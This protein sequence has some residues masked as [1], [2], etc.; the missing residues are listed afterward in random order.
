MNA[1]Q[2]LNL[3]SLRKSC[4]HCALHELCLP[5]GIDADG[6]ERLD[7]LVEKRWLDEG[8]TLFH[9]GMPFDALYVV[10]SGSLRTCVQGAD[11]DLH[12]LGFHLPGE[13][14]GFD[15]ISSGQHAC[16][17]QALE[18]TGYCELPYARLQQLAAQVPALQSQ[19]MRVVSRE[20]IKDQQ[21]LVLLGKQQAQQRVAIFLNSLSERYRRLQRDGDRLT[22]SMSRRDIA[23]YLGLVIETVSRS[24]GRL[25]ELGVLAVQRR[26]I[27]ILQPERLAQLCTA[28]AAPPSRGRAARD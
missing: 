6:M 15:A 10:R 14:V 3:D 1:C 19:L 11:G 8:Q 7:Q 28:E 13:L 26:S 20:I 9:A 25:E 2:P 4:S 12:V 5:A 18:R 16:D 17:A 21:H 23:S 24:L 22:L 27:E